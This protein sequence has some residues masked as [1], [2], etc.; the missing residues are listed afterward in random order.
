[1]KFDFYS[2]NRIFLGTY[3]SLSLIRMRFGEDDDGP[4]NA[5]GTM[6]EIV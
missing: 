3:I 6:A 2:M 4:N 1:M 5:S